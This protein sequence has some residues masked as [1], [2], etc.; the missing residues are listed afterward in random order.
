VRGSA[1]N[2]NGWSRP[3]L[4]DENKI[5]KLNSIPE[6]LGKP[7]VTSKGLGASLNL[8]WPD[9]ARKESGLYY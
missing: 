5:I 1:L 6:K 3:S 9:A 4:M 8:A 7:Y 2:K